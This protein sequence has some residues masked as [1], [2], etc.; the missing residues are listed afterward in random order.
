[1]L[2][3]AGEIVGAGAQFGVPAFA[4]TPDFMAAAIARHDLGQ[5]ASAHDLNAGRKQ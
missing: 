1:M 3:R 2:C 5:W 4:C